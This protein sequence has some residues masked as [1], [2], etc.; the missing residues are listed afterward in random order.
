M[1]P[2]RI[3]Q[4]SGFDPASYSTGQ[5]TGPDNT[6]RST[7]RPST[8]DNPLF[9]GLRSRP[10]FP[11]LPGPADM[12]RGAPA[13]TLPELPGVN[14]MLTT[15]PFAG[16]QSSLA[17]HTDSGCLSEL[18]GRHT[19]QDFRGAPLPS[20]ASLDSRVSGST[21]A[22]R[23]SAASGQYPPPSVASTSTG[24]VPASIGDRQRP[25]PYAPSSS[26]SS[27]TGMVGAG[28]GPSAP[29]QGPEVSKSVPYQRQ[30]VV[31]PATGET[32]SKA[33]LYQRQKRRGE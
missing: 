13:S 24:R 12:L 3:G 8:E 11:R 30:K 14:G 22:S 4:G 10:A 26:R 25:G 19:T 18:I 23:F 20:G 29:V 21:H 1:D 16:S 6:R 33:A 15:G 27:G 32:I 5:E 31:D 2:S 7:N 9:S 17:Q 28:P